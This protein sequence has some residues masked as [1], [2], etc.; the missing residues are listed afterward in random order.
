VGK[1]W[2]YIQ[3]SGAD[4]S[5]KKARERFT[6][7][8]AELAAVGAKIN[9]PILMIH[10]EIRFDV[11]VPEGMEAQV[12]AIM[13]KYFPNPTLG[14]RERVGQIMSQVGPTPLT[15]DVTPRHGQ[16]WERLH[17]SARHASWRVS[18]TASVRRERLRR[19]FPELPQGLRIRV[20]RRDLVA[21]VVHS[22]GRSSVMSLEHDDRHNPRGFENP[23]D[24]ARMHGEQFCGAVPEGEGS[25]PRHCFH[26]TGE[27]LAC[28][29]CGDCFVGDNAHS[30]HGDN[31]HPLT[32]R[33]VEVVTLMAEGLSNKLIAERLDISDHT[34]KFH[35]RAVTK[36][37]GQQTR[38]GAAVAAIRR[39]IVP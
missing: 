25:Y 8:E 3:S 5:A 2:P 6:S 29:W 32:P 28:C 1:E 19:P 33:E 22:A 23:N 27:N 39:G 10:D 38:T 26:G 12:A 36:R 21:A 20:G 17:R 18:E 13:D 37:L 24:V 9:V 34:A 15:L 16:T 11:D 30:V 14:L 7:L 35:V 4:V 31:F